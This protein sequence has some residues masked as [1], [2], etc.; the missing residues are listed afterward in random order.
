MIH[1]YLGEHCGLDQNFWYA[2]R[3]GQQ[4][5]G[6]GLFENLENSFIRQLCWVT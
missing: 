5:L 4:L 3:L 2:T 6:P 1:F